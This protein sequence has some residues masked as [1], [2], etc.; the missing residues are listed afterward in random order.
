VQASS[1]ND[2]SQLLPVMNDPAFQAAW[3]VRPAQGEQTDGKDDEAAEEKVPEGDEAEDILAEAIV[4]EPADTSV[5][6]PLLWRSLMTA[7]ENLSTEGATVGE[8]TYRVDRRRH[9]AAFELD[10]GTLHFNREDFV[11]VE[12][13]DKKGNWR[14]LG[15]LDVTISNPHLVAINASR[16]FPD[17]RDGLIADDTRLRFRSHWETTSRTRREAATSR[18]LSRQSTTRELID[19]FDAS[20]ENKPTS[21]RVGESVDYFRERYSLNEIQAKAFKELV[22]LRPLGLLQGPPGTGKTYF[23]GAFIHYAL[24]SGLAKNVLLASQAHEAVNNAAEAVL[25]LF[26]PS[27]GRPSIVR[28]GQEGSVSERLLPFHSWR[29]ETAYKDRFNANLKERMRVIGLTLGVAHSLCDDL[30]YIEQTLRPVAERIQTL[31][32]SRAASAD[33]RLPGLLQTL[34]TMTDKLGIKLPVDLSE[35]AGDVLDRVVS[36]AAAAAQ[37]SSNPDAVARFRAATQLARDFIGAVSTQERSFETFLAGTRQIVAGTCVGLGRSSLGLTSTPFDLV[38]VDEAARCTASEL[39]VPLQSGRWIVLVGDQAQLEPVHKKEVVDTVAIQTQISRKEI[40]RSDFERVFASDYGAEAGRQLTQQYRMLAPIGRIVSAAFYT[41]AL[42]HERSKPEIDPSCLPESLRN[43]VTWISTDAS[44][45]RGHQRRDPM[46]TP[47]LINPLEA[48]IIVD[49]LKRWDAHP[50]F[51]TYQEMH[52]LPRQPIGVIC[53]YAAQRDL[54][55]NKMRISGF[56][57]AMKSAVMIGTVDS[58]QGKENPIVVLSLVRNNDEGAKQSGRETIRQ[59]FMVRPNRVNV[60]F[61]RAMD[62]LVVVGARAGWPSGGPMHRAATAFAREVDAGT[63]CVIE[64]TGIRGPAA[65]GRS[66]GKKP[67]RKKGAP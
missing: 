34:A 47:S 30:L 23:I 63:A 39:T 4:A 19:L 3:K 38:V 58:Y 21:I 46:G 12:R 28:V 53:M 45:E 67:S 56:S 14:D 49:L 57:E 18:V 29:V 24:T 43:V 65:S 54:L 1:I 15:L 51:R 64:A 2:F 42:S 48:D 16:K 27:E 59:G 35:G 13:L 52:N 62:R 61:S 22:S 17:A 6:V 25:K 26:D 33:D 36:D 44:A 66:S 9:F 40:K 55:R 50:P 31:R 7:E 20:N 5:D 8:S 10:E 60:A 41:K 32:E 11:F 37:G